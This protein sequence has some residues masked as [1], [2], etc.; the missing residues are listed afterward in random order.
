MKNKL[1]ALMLFVAATATRSLAATTTCGLPNAVRYALSQQSH[2]DGL[3]P[4]DILDRSDPC[5]TA[6]TAQA[7]STFNA[8]YANRDFLKI[9]ESQKPDTAHFSECALSAK[10]ADRRVQFATAALQAG[11]NVLY[12]AV[13]MVG[14]SP[15]TAARARHLQVVAKWILANPCA[16]HELKSTARQELRELRE[17]VGP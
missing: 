10:S 5:T 4:I 17:I 2:Q 14:V 9:S 11:E 16:N 15:L 6:G 13:K 3:S 8:E 7:A 12:S 1:L